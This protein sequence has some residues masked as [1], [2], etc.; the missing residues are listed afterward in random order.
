MLKQ[1]SRGREGSRQQAGLCVVCAWC[2]RVCACVVCLRC[3]MC[4]PSTVVRQRLLARAVHRTHLAPPPATFKHVSMQPQDGCGLGWRQRWMLLPS[5]EASAER[6]APLRIPHPLQPAG[7]QE[8]PGSFRS[9]LTAAVPPLESHWTPRRRPRR[10]AGGRSSRSW[11]RRRQSFHRSQHSA[12][13]CTSNGPCLN[14]EG[15][16]DTAGGTG[17]RGGQKR[18][19]AL[20]L[21]AIALDQ[22]VANVLPGEARQV[23]RPGRLKP[24]P[25]RPRRRQAV[26]AAKRLRRRR[27]EAYTLHQTAHN[28]VMGA[29]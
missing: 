26:R 5:P 9:L 27:C 4:V 23:E 28:P 2:V 25:S 19:A 13:C 3:V 6:T 14:I 16:A 11:S 21:R 1:R 22:A 8:I 20:A 10:P 15:V 24:Q 17:A 12:G 7:F 29:S 18:A